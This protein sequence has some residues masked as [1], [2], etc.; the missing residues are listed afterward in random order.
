MSN[1]TA[2]ATITNTTSESIDSMDMK[3]RKWD[4]CLTTEKALAIMGT[5]EF[6][7]N[8]TYETFSQKSEYIR[9]RK[10]SNGKIEDDYHKEL[11]RFNIIISRYIRRIACQLRFCNTAPIERDAN[12]DTVRAMIMF[13]EGTPPTTDIA[14]H[15]RHG[16]RSDEW[17]ELQEEL[18]QVEK[19]TIFDRLHARALPNTPMMKKNLG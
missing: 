10:P 5:G 6:G 9:R 12:L 19:N 4:F 17:D 3:A 2:P 15:I 14:W 16:I 13:I 8:Y 7:T 11:T 1:T 18:D